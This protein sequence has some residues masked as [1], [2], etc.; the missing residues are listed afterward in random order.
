MRLLFQKNDLI[1]AIQ[2]VGRAVASKTTMSI[3]ECILIDATDGQ[4]TLTGN[5]TEFGIETICP[6]IIEEA[7]KVALE[8]KLFQEIVKRL[9]QTEENNLY[10]ETVENGNCIISCEKSIFKSM[11]RKAEEFPSLPF[12]EKQEA[13]RV[14]QFSLRNMINQTI[15]STANGENNKR[16]AGEYFEIKDN[17]FSITSLDGHRISIRKTFLKDSYTEQ[18]AIVPKEV[19]SDL[20][21]ILTG[22]IEDMV[23]MY[24]SGQYLLFHYENTTVVTQLVEGEYF[25]VK[26]MLSTD[27]ETSI[28]VNRKQFMENIDRARILARDNDKNPLI[29][30]IT[31]NYLF[32]KIISDLGRMDAEIPIKKEGNELMIA[33]NPNFLMDALQNIEEEEVSLYFT[34]PRSPVFIRDKEESYIYMILPVNFNADQVE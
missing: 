18:S 8:A 7:G 19:L 27:Y 34:I 6:G 11:G 21:K 29:F 33:F 31:E 5:K 24:F 14:S 13:V 10:I 26:Q 12:V 3:M 23:E 2:I 15:F 16:M 30:K 9:P 22:D 20:A 4:I 28:S 32:L 1:S 25:H 17:L